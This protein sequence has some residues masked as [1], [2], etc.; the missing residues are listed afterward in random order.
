MALAHLQ[1][2]T[3]DPQR[4]IHLSGRIYLGHGRIVPDAWINNN[5]ITFLRPSHVPQ[6]IKIT[7]FVLPGLVDM[8]CHVGLAPQGA[9][10]LAQA[11]TQALASL[12]TGVTLIRD[13]GSPSDTTAL[14]K[15]SD[16]PRLVRSGAHLA[17]PK[18]YLRGYAR[19]LENVNQL[20]QAVAE[21]AQRSGGWVKIVGDWIDRTKGAQADLAP[22]WPREVLAEAVAAAHAESARVTIHVFSTQGA[23]DAIA[24]GV[25]CIEHGTGLTDDLI[26]EL[27]QRQTPVVP[28]LLQVAEFENIAALADGKYPVY[29]DRMRQMH[30]QRYSHVAKLHAAGVP[31]FIGTDAGGTISHGAIAAECAELVKAGIPPAEVIAM[32]SWRAR[33]FLGQGN[34]IEGS[35]ADFVVYHS[36]PGSNIEALQR[37]SSVILRGRI[38]Q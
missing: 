19:E 20:P 9:V 37:P 7:G 30:A 14:T 1:A 31:L 3:L 11:E 36:D 22:L 27:A 34:I 17:L 8:H 38:L 33:D 4:I 18:R 29:A 2:H 35:Q 13:A 10:D 15:R 28:T 24:A 16:L 23:Q 21:E 26:T 12:R 32:A 5:Q 6:P 25:D